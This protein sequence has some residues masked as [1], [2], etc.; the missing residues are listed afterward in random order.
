ML[1]ED[2]VLACQEH[3]DEALDE[4]LLVNETFPIMNKASEGKCKYCDK[5]A[6]YSLEK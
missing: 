3:I 6:E 5:K 2:K 1:V 4:F